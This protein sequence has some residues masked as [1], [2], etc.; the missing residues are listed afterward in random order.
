MTQSTSSAFV[1]ELRPPWPATPS[2]R[3]FG[4]HS[5]SRIKAAPA[6]STQSPQ[7]TAPPRPVGS[8]P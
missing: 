4:P 1:D 3:S 6:A 7:P 5:A 2:V 8:A